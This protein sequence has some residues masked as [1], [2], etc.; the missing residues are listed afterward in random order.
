VSVSACHVAAQVLES[1]HVDVE[2]SLVTHSA[3]LGVKNSGPP[4]VKS[5]P[6]GNVEIVGV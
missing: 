3:L 4:S 6:M 2:L 1:G 5:K